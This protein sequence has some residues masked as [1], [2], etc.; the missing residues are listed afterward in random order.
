MHKL[1]GKVVVVSKEGWIVVIEEKVTVIFENG[2]VIANGEAES[3]AEPSSAA[4]EGEVVSEAVAPVSVEVNG[5]SIAVT[6]DGIA[7]LVNFQWLVGTEGGLILESGGE[8]VSV[9]FDGT[10]VIVNGEKWEW[11]RL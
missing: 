6:F 2:K 3:E 9:T 11:V 10:N 7:S 1:N 8:E 5:E 4:S